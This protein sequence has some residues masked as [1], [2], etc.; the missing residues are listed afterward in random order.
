MMLLLLLFVPFFQWNILPRGDV[1]SASTVLPSCFVS[2]VPERGRCILFF[3]LLILVA[4]LKSNRRDVERDLGKR[5]WGLLQTWVS[6][7]VDFFGGFWG[8]ARGGWGGRL[9]F[10]IL[11]YLFGY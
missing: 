2:L 8:S 9:L 11:F 4:P 10:Y 3:C 5:N 7:I 6:Y 1:L